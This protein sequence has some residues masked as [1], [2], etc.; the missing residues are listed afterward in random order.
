MGIDLL[1]TTSPLYPPALTPPRMPNS[2]NLDINTYEAWPGVDASNRYIDANLGRDEESELLRLTTT[3]DRQ[4]LALRG[5]AEFC[6]L[7]WVKT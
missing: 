2:I 6:F 1:F 4:D 3:L 5:R 7:R